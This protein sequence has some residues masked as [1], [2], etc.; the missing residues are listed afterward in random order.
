M[1][2]GARKSGFN[3]YRKVGRA[4]IEKFTF[5]PKIIFTLGAPIKF[6]PTEYYY[7]LYKNVVL[8]NHHKSIQNTVE[9]HFELVLLH[10]LQRSDFFNS[11]LVQLGHRHS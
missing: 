2:L 5:T 9:I 7:I 4:T 11:Y 8:C 1:H 6:L 3:C 10:K